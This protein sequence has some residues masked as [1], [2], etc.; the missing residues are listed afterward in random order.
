MET[1]LAFPWGRAVYWTRGKACT[2]F[3]R[4]RPLD[5]PLAGSCVLEPTA[6]RRVQWPRPTLAVQHIAKS[7]FLN[8]IMKNLNRGGT[9]M[10]YMHFNSSCA[11]ADLENLWLLKL[12][13]VAQDRPDVL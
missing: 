7:Q 13:D 10:K 3:C 11:Y 5:V 2:A 8:Q 12:P 4:A 1:R 6:K 9:K